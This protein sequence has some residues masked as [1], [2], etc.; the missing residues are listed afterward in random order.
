MGIDAVKLQKTKHRRLSILSNS[1]SNISQIEGTEKEPNDEFDVEHDG[2][3]YDEY[4]PGDTLQRNDEIM[5]NDSQTPSG[6]DQ[7]NDVRLKHKFLKLCDTVRTLYGSLDSLECRN[8]ELEHALTRQRPISQ[9]QKLEFEQLRHERNEFAEECDALRCELSGLKDANHREKMQYDDMRKKY[10][11]ALH[12]KDELRR[13]VVQNLHDRFKNSGQRIQSDVITKNYM[14]WHNVYDLVVNQQKLMNEL[15]ESKES[16]EEYKVHINK[17]TKRFKVLN[18]TRIV[19][20]NEKAKIESVLEEMTKRIHILEGNGKGMKEE[21][22]NDD[23]CLKNECEQQLTPLDVS[24]WKQYAQEREKEHD[25]YRE[26]KQQQI[27]SL[28]CD[29]IKIKN[30]NET[31]ENQQNES[32]KIIDALKRKNADFEQME[33]NKLEELNA[34]N[35]RINTLNIEQKSNLQQIRNYKNQSVEM[36]RRLQSFENEKTAF[37]EQIV[38]FK[39]II[40]NLQKNISQLTAKQIELKSNENNNEQ[41][42]IDLQSIL[43]QSKEKD[44]QFLTKQSELNKEIN[45]LMIT[46]SEYKKEKDS[47]V[48]ELEQTKLQM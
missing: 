36:Q 10:A 46:N 21:M 26:T 4:I 39:Q 38:S 11:K 45:T 19:A 28:Q 35:V 8:E 44:L 20:E 1:N 9:Q 24:E 37:N 13:N 29:M 15:R 48:K 14:D 2:E 47:I 30:Q 34:L 41:S 7:I 33:R 3:E 42:F 25:L 16:L 32:H 31:M 18:E 23:N 5:A 22:D 17:A 6:F 27:E 12:E 40:N 43:E